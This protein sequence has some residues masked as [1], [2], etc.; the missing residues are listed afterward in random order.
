MQ[1]SSFPCIWSVHV[2]IKHG[3]IMKGFPNSYIR[4]LLPSIS[5][6]V[7]YSHSNVPDQYEVRYYNIR[8]PGL[9]VVQLLID[10]SCAHCRFAGLSICL[11][12]TPTEFL[13][14]LVLGLCGNIISTEAKKSINCKFGMTPKHQ[15]VRRKSCTRVYRYI[16][17]MIL[18]VRF[19][20]FSKLYP[21]S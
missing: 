3:L 21:A 6:L 7:F 18:P 15:I 5:N 10:I 17:H 2:D 16:I 13:C 12:K 14:I 8:C 19:L 9:S 11:S 20:V 4:I 1:A